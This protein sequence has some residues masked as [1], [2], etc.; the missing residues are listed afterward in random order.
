MVTEVDYL[1]KKMK[2][3]CKH[4]FDGEGLQG[5]LNIPMQFCPYCGYKLSKKEFN[6]YNGRLGKN[7]SFLNRVGVLLKK[8]NKFFEIKH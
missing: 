4:F 3:C 2:S 7:H 1:E 8:R 5:E 6:Y